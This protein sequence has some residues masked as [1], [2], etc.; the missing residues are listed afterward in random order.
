M[1]STDAQAKPSRFSSFLTILFTYFFM[2]TLNSLNLLIKFTLKKFWLLQ[3]IL[4]ILMLNIVIAL[5]IIEVRYWIGS[6]AV[7]EEE[8]VGL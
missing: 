1:S 6:T 2:F 4:K 7:L 5:L 3:D 8:A